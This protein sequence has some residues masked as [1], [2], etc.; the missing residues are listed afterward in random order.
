VGG[1]LRD[2][3]KSSPGL[4][5]SGGLNEMNFDLPWPVGGQGN[6]FR[7]AGLARVFRDH[8]LPVAARATATTWSSLEV[9]SRGFT[10]GIDGC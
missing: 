6:W 2:F 7:A 3:L 10:H 1:G 5:V 8:L 4:Q 9:A